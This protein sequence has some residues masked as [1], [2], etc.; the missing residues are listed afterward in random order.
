M[1][2]QDIEEA[3]FMCDRILVLSSNLGRIVAEITVPFAHPRNRLDGEFRALVDEIYAKMTA[4]QSGETAKHTLQ[5]SSRLPHVSTNLL[6]GLIKTLAAAPY[7][8]RADLPVI[9]RSLHLEIDDLFP[10]VEM[11]RPGN[12]GDFGSWL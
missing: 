12:V 7:L 6:A 11:K 1:I 4:R 10:I 8:G 5:F 2:G 3:V 9:A